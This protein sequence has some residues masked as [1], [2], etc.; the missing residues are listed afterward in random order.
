MTLQISAPVD[1]SVVPLAEVPDPV[2]AE[3]LVGPGAAIDPGDA[4][5]LTAVAPV[6]GTVS[7]LKPH[8]F[9]IV[10]DD[11]RGV[12]VHLGIDTVEL[13]GAG[14]ALRAEKGQ[15]VN[16]GDALVDWDT[17]AAREAG[18]SLVVPVIVLDAE[19]ASLTTTTATAVAVGDTLIEAE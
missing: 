4:A 7:S 10:D 13:Q 19:A 16:A 9:V 15:S 3:A 2:F 18:K 12:L 14:F 11:G 17:K 8:A 1:G 5:T 6:A